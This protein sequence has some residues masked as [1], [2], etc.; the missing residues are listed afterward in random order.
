MLKVVEDH[1]T[2]FYE[3]AMMTADPTKAWEMTV[4]ETLFAVWWMIRAVVQ[5]VATISLLTV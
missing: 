1:A 5:V 2:V 4:W 3:V